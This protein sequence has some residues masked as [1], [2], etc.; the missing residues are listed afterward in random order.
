[1]NSIGDTLRR[2]RRRRNLEISQIAGDLKISGRFLEAMERDDFAK[3]PGGVFTK[4]FIRQYAGYLGLDAEELVVGM[5]QS[6]DPQPE[7]AQLPE[8]PKPDVPGMQLQIGENWQSITD[9]P[10]SLPSWVKAGMLLVVLM[11]VCSGAYYWW[12]ERPRHQVLAHE[13]LPPPRTVPTTKPTAP[14][15]QPAAN[16]PAPLAQ[17][18]TAQTSAEPHGTPPPTQPA[19]APPSAV[20]AIPLSAPNP[21]A[22]VRVNISADDVV[23]V[24]A[25]VNGKVQFAGVLQPH[26]SRNIDADGEVVV[27]LGNAGGATLTWNGKPVGG[28]GPKGQVRDVQF[29]SGGFQI[30]SPA[31]SLDPLDRL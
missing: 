1:M 28:V 12:W 20:P 16:Q 13:V 7:F 31:K 30:V 2:E 23:W 6:A 10:S 25:A 3:L 9:R 29:T 14:V 21:N 4:S 22:T 27:R 8:K 15:S 19:P 5:E 24:R 26:E 18:A 17:P 11:L